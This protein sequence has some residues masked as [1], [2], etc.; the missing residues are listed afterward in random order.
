MVHGWCLLA[1]TLSQGIAPAGDVGAVHPGAFGA[2]EDTSRPL[3]VA[4]G[5]N[6]PGQSRQPRSP[7]A[8]DGGQRVAFLLMSHGRARAV[9]AVLSQVRRAYPV[10]EAELFVYECGTRVAEVAATRFGATEYRTIDNVFTVQPGSTWAT[11]P[12]EQAALGWLRAL[13]TA[14][15][16][17]RA[18]HLVLLEPDVWIRRRI[19]HFPKAALGGIYVKGNYLEGA[20]LRY[21]R[22]A[23]GTRWR[24]RA[25]LQ[26]AA[27]GGCVLQVSK[28]RQALKSA[29]RSVGTTLRPARWAGDELRVG[30]ENGLARRHHS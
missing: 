20:P 10:G 8:M 12:S 6:E 23:L 15:Q 3:L 28:M 5:A 27:A 17:T 14:L 11:F 22:S 24:S 4:D 26:Y 25:T 16:A 19:A 2:R 29:M 21:A 9:E 13:S 30:L 18:R 1:L 7:R